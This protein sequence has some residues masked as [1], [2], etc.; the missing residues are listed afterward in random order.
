[1]AEYREPSKNTF[2]KLRTHYDNRTILLRADQINLIEPGRPGSLISTPDTGFWNSPYHVWERP[3][4]IIKMM[5]E[6]SPAGDH[7]RG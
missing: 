4:E 5:A 1:M 6:S 7:P 2:I 3:E